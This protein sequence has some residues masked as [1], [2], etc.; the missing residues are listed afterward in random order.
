LIAAATLA[1][2]LALGIKQHTIYKS[3]GTRFD[4]IDTAGEYCIFFATV[5]G[6]HALIVALS[7]YLFKQ[8]LPN[9]RRP[10]IMLDF[11]FLFGTAFLISLAARAKLTSIL[12][13]ALSLQLIRGLG[14]GDLLAALVYSLGDAGFAVWIACGCGIFYLAARQVMRL[15]GSQISDERVERTPRRHIRRWI[16]A[17]SV[18]ALLFAAGGNKD[19]R[20]ALDRFAAPWLAY[21]LLEFATDFD[22]DGY[23]LFSLHRDWQP[24]DAEQHPFALD[25]PGNGI[26]EDGLAGDYLHRAGG[27]F[28][29]ALNFGAERR[30]VILIV[31]EST[32]ADV[33]GARWRGRLVAPHLVGLA[34]AGVHSEEAYSHVGYTRPSLKT[35]LTGRLD[36]LT[37]GKS[38]FSEFRQAGYRVGVLSAQ[39]EDFGD[40]AKDTGMRSNADVFIDAN[41]VRQESWKVGTTDITRNLDGRVLIRE[42]ARHFG[43]RERWAQ[44]TFL[45]VNIQASHY[46][47]QYPGTPQLLPGR[48]VPRTEIRFENRVWTRRTYWNSVAYG[49]WIIGRL[50]AQL[51]RVGA[52]EEGVLLIVADHGEEL[53]ENKY[54][55]HGQRL[56]DLQTRIPFITNRKNLAI[57]RP[58]GLSDIRELLLHA[59]GAEI[60]P[61]RAGGAIFQHT[62]DLNRPAEIAMVEA[63]RRRTVFRL[64]TGEVLYEEAGR[65]TSRG[66]YQRLS[67]NSRLRRKAD[68]VVRMWERER[69][70]RHLEL[71]SRAR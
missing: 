10:L 42:L 40:I 3:S 1:A 65:Q 56:N 5:I 43:D 14:G 2:E 13:D 9:R 25:R 60:P 62:A 63:G 18:P 19:V 11:Y 34:S 59:A 22:R 27:E 45:Y 70:I 15:R 68:Q 54:V 51:K 29:S 21:A 7:F 48:P 46:P 69:W 12:G 16:T 38:L 52:L 36:P 64:H 37:P 67:S 30:H 32:R 71:S 31:M 28:S 50:V 58:V 24:F 33:L 35:L 39:A 57:P 53:F 44:P 49:D 55:G 4:I 26:D 41:T 17:L 47:Y 66:L 23:S 20:V 61:P 6:A 8:F